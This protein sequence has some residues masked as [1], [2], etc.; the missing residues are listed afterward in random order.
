M[1][2][3][4][5]YNFLKSYKL[6]DPQPVSKEFSY[7]FTKGNTYKIMLCLEDERKKSNIEMTILDKTRKIV[8]SNT[9]SKG[10]KKYVIQFKC[11]A[12]GIYYMHY[13]F[14]DE[15]HFCGASLLAFNR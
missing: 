4:E 3:L 14:K 10:K 1:R 13:E 6:V 11:D 9:S 5:D 15:G 8:A 7:V 2:K 12:S